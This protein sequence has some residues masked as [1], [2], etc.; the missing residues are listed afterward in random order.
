MADIK[1]T[2]AS[3]LARI[4]V[5]HPWLILLIAFVITVISLVLSS[6]LEMRMNW[7]DI[8]PEDNPVVKSY[9]DVQDRFGDG[10][11]IV[12]ALEGDYERICAMADTILPYLEEL[13]GLYN[14]QGRV[15]LDYIKDHGFALLKPDDFER[16]LKVFSDPSLTG[17]LRGINDDYEREYTDSESNLRRDEVDI[18][19]SLLGMHRALEVLTENITPPRS[20]GG[21][22]KGGAGD[23]KNIPPIETAVDA[24]TLGEPW[25]ISLDR[26]MLLIICETLHSQ[27]EIKGMLETTLETEKVMDRFRPLF[28]DVSANLTGI[29]RIGQDEM[30]S[31]GIYTIFLSIGALLLIYL[32]LARS[33]RGWVL[34]LMALLPLMIGIFWTTGLLYLLFGS[35]NLF[36]AMIMIVLLGLGIDFAIHT[37][38]RFNEETTKGK[39]TEEALSTMLSSTGVAVITGGLTS[40]AAFLT[41]LIGKSSGVFEFGA[42][43]GFGVLL[44]L[45]AILFILPPIL[46][47]RVR[48]LR[49][50]RQEKLTASNETF[51]TTIST[52]SEAFPIIGKIARTGWRHPWIFIS[53]TLL[54]CIF[55]LWAKRHIEFEYDWLELE[56]KGLKSIQLQR[57]IPERFGMS[58][59]AS[60][61]VVG[62]VEESRVLKEQFKKKPL[63][64]DV[65]A[66]SDYIPPADRLESYRLRLLEFRKSLALPP[67][68]GLKTSNGL[69]APPP[70]RAGGE[71]LIRPPPALRGGNLRGG[72]VAALHLRP[73]NFSPK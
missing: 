66:I 28:P 14:V 25:F 54:V 68:P 17:T 38:S 44:T 22:S 60:W 42:A 7:S 18:A 41:L 58:D 15:P 70:R 24:I 13:D 11:G 49:K 71:L 9:R 35:L 53:I 3:K 20:A 47:I 10:S 43:A 30:E 39:S 65:M 51:D 46:A 50:R 34:P 72:Y 27:L 1:D 19:R 23:E 55:S 32:L 64:G 36:T 12:I 56:P 4:S 69:V 33:F 31:V 57:E 62:S 48:V 21:E 63:V 37:I 8:L 52:A 26:H 40:A 2:L 16:M 6:G 45:A 5:D 73:A 29:A 61:M 59:H 67:S